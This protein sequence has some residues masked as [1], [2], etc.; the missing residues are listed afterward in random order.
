MEKEADRSAKEFRRRWQPA[1]AS[2]PDPDGYVPK[3]LK[4]PRGHDLATEHAKEVVLDSVRALLDLHYEKKLRNRAWERY[5]KE[6]REKEQK[7]SRGEEEV[8]GKEPKVREV[9]SKVFAKVSETIAEKRFETFVLPPEVKALL[10]KPA[11]E[12]SWKN[13]ETLRGT[14][15]SLEGCGNPAKRECHQRSRSARW[16][17]GPGIELKAVWGVISH[18]LRW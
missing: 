12:R 15:S 11:D 16:A 13:A 17:F 6:L 2:S 1:P 5:R 14:S 9:R 4:F 3:T 7:R 18:L 10:Q 8:E